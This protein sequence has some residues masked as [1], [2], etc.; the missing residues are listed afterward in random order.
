MAWAALSSPFGCLPWAGLCSTTAESHSSS[1]CGQRN[2]GND[3]RA[4]T[5]C[6]SM[7]PQGDVGARCC[8]RLALSALGKL[9]EEWG[10]RGVP[11]SHHVPWTALGLAWLSHCWSPGAVLWLFHSCRRHPS[12]FFPERVMSLCIVPLIW[13]TLVQTCRSQGV[14]WSGPTL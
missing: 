7:Y 2:P 10:A 12:L 6:G 3:F 1:R 13:V 14:S 4:Q 5:P 9:G 8:L 11:L